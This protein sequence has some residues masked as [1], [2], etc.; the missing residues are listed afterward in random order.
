MDKHH[1]KILSWTQNSSGSQYL[2]LRGLRETPK[3]HTILG[4]FG[5]IEKK[6]RR[7]SYLITTFKIGQKEQKNAYESFQNQND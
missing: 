6:V 7:I 1:Q 2:R 5:S 4:N 3:S